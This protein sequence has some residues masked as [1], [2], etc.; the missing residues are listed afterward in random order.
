MHISRSTSRD[1][2]W[3]FA[4]LCLLIAW[5]ASG[6]DLLLARPW[7]SAQG[8]RLH[9]NWFLS[10]VLHDGARRAA[11]IP[12]LWLIVG[13]W[14]PTGILRRLSRAQ[15]VQWAG[16]T[17]LALAAISLFK[18]ASHTSCP[19]DLIEFGGH[20]R[21]IS[22]WAWGVRDGGPGHCFPAGHA[23]AAFA[24]ISGYFVLRSVSPVQARAWLIG[25]LLAGLVLGAAQQ[26]RGAHFMS[27]TFW[28]GWLCWT[29]AW[30]VDTA[31]RRRHR[32]AA[33]SGAIEPPLEKAN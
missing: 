7:A 29:I 14:K 27:H 1:L 18:H 21:W 12:A 33:V 15:R 32:K 4:T 31:V 5:D 30:L 3:T 25:A 16:T 19:W 2:L 9:D 22:H 28:T 10:T 6:L 26:L 24:F 17:L 11:W 20:A 13:V 23:S 8:F